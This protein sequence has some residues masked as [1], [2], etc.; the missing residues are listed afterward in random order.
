MGK[1]EDGG[2]PGADG[3]ES[4]GWEQAM[5]RALHRLDCPSALEL[6]EARLAFLSGHMPAGR[7]QEIE[8]H[9]ES[10][11]YCREEWEQL[12]ESK[13]AAFSAVKPPV[14]KEAQEPGVIPFRPVVTYYAGDC[15]E[16]ALSA[17]RRDGPLPKQQ[18]IEIPLGGQTPL[19]LFYRFLPE[20][21]GRVFQAQFVPGADISARLGGSQ[22]EIWQEQELLYLKQIGDLYAF[23]CLLQND[24]PLLIRVS[25]A[26][27]T[28]LSF[29]LV[30][31]SQSGGPESR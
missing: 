24:S 13:Q 14:E 31:E 7:K 20:E 10:C 17:L 15:G 1:Y 22:I 19:I 2:N 30:P 8:R 5:H 26:N 11:P 16:E 29:P 6:G 12:R 18:K 21:S 4:A 25:D 28:W 27:A 23:K 3:K 9:L